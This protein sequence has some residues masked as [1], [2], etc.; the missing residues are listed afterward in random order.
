[1][2]KLIYLGIIL[3]GFSVNTFCVEEKTLLFKSEELKDQ[4]KVDMISK[5]ILKKENSQLSCNLR[6][7]NTTN[8]TQILEAVQ[9]KV[10]I[11]ETDHKNGQIVKRYANFIF[12]ENW[13]VAPGDFAFY[14]PLQ[15]QIEQL[16]NRETERI[17]RC[18]IESIQYGKKTKNVQSLLPVNF[19]ENTIIALDHGLKYHLA[20]RKS[21][22]KQL[23]AYKNDL[24][25][26]TVGQSIKISGLLKIE[27]T[28][29]R[30]E[31]VPRNAYLILMVG[32][33]HWKIKIKTQKLKKGESVNQILNE[34]HLS[35]TI[36]KSKIA[37]R[38]TFE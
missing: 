29:S 31:K 24:E 14:H 9:I 13:I 26:E 8:E 2:T 20:L 6:I 3:L 28:T 23:G 10:E 19:G 17:S 36:I 1:M 11:E 18:Q 32:D 34:T 22:N 37:S 33:Q 30:T 38:I 25:S 27:N 5:L 35:K 7:F 4:L 16:K 12:R 15:Q 21:Y